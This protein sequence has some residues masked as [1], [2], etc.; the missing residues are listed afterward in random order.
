MTDASYSVIRYIPDAGRGERL[1]IGVLVWAGDEFRLSLDDEA[2]KRVIRE[3]PRLERDSLLYVAPL[4]AERLSSAVVPVPS[5]IQRLLEGQ[6]GFPIDLSEPLFTTVDPQDE[7]GLDATLDRL[8]D[9]VVT[10]KRRRPPPRLNPAQ[11]LESRLKPLIRS[12]SVTRNHFFGRTK[13]GVPR[14]AEF[15]ANSGA[16]VALDT[17][18]LALQDADEIRR[19]ADAEA[20]KVYDVLGADETV[21]QY[22]VFCEFGQK[23]ADFETTHHNARTVIETQ[24]A[25]IVTELD[26]AADLLTKAVGGR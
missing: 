16:N 15:F 22:V 9:R 19:R 2:V 10:P 8:I 12:E 7:G 26:E 17:L 11:L 1:N 13:T 18:R 4:L 24:G 21:R 3:N 6:R 25:K 14:T 23:G 5:Q 20:F